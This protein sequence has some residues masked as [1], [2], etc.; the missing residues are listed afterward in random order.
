MGRRKGR[1]LGV[2]R[3]G[4]VILGVWKDRIFGS[5]EDKGGFVS[6]K[7]WAVMALKL[8]GVCVGRRQWRYL[9]LHR[10]G[11]AI[12]GVWKEK[13]FGWVM[14]GKGFGS[15]IRWRV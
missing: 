9:G 4:A 3:F 8:E 13:E 1:D 2:I 12:V 11:A 6:P 14:P 15:H 10:F 7:F 5:V